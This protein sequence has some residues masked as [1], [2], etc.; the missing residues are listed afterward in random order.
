MRSPDIRREALRRKTFAIIS[1]PDAGKTTLTEKLLLYGGAIQLAGAV[2]AKKARAHAVSDWMEMERE[3]GIS[4]VSSV[5][6][7]PYA[8]RDLN[9]VDTPGHADFSEDTYRAIMAT[10][11]AVMLL[12][13]A[14]GVE[15]QT[16]KLFRVCKMRKMPIF[17]FVNK[18]DRPGREPI[19]LV[20]EVEDV[21]G[22][23]VY[24]ITWPVL[25][26]GRFRGVY[27][28]VEHRVH[29]FDAVAHGAERAPERHFA[30]DDP[31]LAE[32][33]DATALKQLRDDI[34]LVDAAGDKLDEEKLAHG[35][36]TPM[37]F[38][39]ALTNFGL[40]QFL[41]AFVEMM[42]LPAPRHSDKGD[43]E[44]DDDRF[45]AFVFKIQA[46]MDRS[47]R[48]RM[49]F[50]RVCSGKYERGMKVRHVR[51]GRDIR[52]TNPTQFLA[53]DRTIVDDSFAGDIMGVFDPGIFLIGDTLTDGLDIAY[54]P[55]PQFPPEYFAR[56][57]MIDPMKR[58]QLKK[59]LEQLAQEGSIQLFRPPEGR[60][61]ESIVGAVG[62]LQFDVVK[63]RLSVEYSVECRIERMSF[64]LAR[65]VEGEPLP[66]A[67]LEGLLF[68]Y[69]A[70]DVHGQP[71]VLFKG[72]WQLDTCAKAFPNTRFVEL[73]ARGP[74]IDRED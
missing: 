57:V 24:P 68:G 21:L 40:P 58:K 74:Q 43:I 36:V 59:G 62:E 33:L 48:D 15:L 35:Q 42:P 14:K 4:I 6:Q 25:E 47:H 16:K 39:S 37:F 65:W 19:E 70:L 61:G 50:L 72:E 38:G 9:L 51:L 63:N 60:E 44:C 29:L 73:G 67:K 41:D 69:G 23:G 28:R 66:L 7:F 22:I 71:V 5:L 31:K 8:G 34:D 10:D 12:D 27:H 52:L 32:E 46:N 3:R 54:D 53:Q 17:T 45:S 1:H 55:L 11:A 26:S 20:G 2:K 64:Q 49:A 30:L 56:I 18:L 13:C